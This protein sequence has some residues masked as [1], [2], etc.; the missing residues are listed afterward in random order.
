MYGRLMGE[1][2]HGEEGEEEGCERRNILWVFF[3]C[4][5]DISWVIFEGMG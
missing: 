5:C 1:E 4:E 2:G 3:M